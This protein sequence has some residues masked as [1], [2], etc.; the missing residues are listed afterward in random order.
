[1]HYMTP[2]RIQK[3][4]ER[5]SALHIPSLASQLVPEN[6]EIHKKRK[7]HH[8]KKIRQGD[9]TRRSSRLRAKVEDD[10]VVKEE[11]VEEEFERMLGEFVIDGQCPKCSKLYQKGHRR[12]LLNCSGLPAPPSRSRIDRQLLT[13]LSEEDK[14]NER[15]KML[16]RMSALSLSGLDDF[17]DDFATIGVYGSTGRRYVVTFQD[18]GDSLQYRDFPRKCECID[19]R[20][21]RRDCKHIC[22]VMQLL[23]IDLDIS[24]EEFNATWR[25]AVNDNMKDL[26]IGEHDVDDIPCTMPESKNANVGRKFLDT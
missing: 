23:G 22:L 5:L 16:A 9:G 24:R 12:H 13:G 14:K 7:D 20:C 1:M 18:A 17:T 21:R 25:D 4:K 8:S 19:S 11:T 15:K 6:T 3:N 2:C 26:I 10:I